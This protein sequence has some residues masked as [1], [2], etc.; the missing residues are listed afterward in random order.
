MDD[1]NGRKQLHYK[2]IP[3]PDW[4]CTAT[5]EKDAQED[6]E[7]GDRACTTDSK[8]HEEDEA[9]SGEDEKAE[10]VHNREADTLNHKPQQ[11]PLK[12]TDTRKHQLKDDGP[13]D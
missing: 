8:D 7:G 6:D 5:K 2:P 12:D 1:D 9:D 13:R 11:D 4:N 10:E 3:G